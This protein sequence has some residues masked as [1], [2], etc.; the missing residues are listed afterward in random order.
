[1]VGQQGCLGQE[2]RQ[3]LGCLPVLTRRSCWRSGTH[4][5]CGSGAAPQLLRGQGAVRTKGAPVPVPGA[6]TALPG[7][8][9]CSLS[10]PGLCLLVCQLACEAWGSSGPCALEQPHGLHCLR[11]ICPAWVA[12]SALFVANRRTPHHLG[13]CLHR[14]VGAFKRCRPA[15][16][17]GK[18]P[19]II[20]SMYIS[21]RNP[22][23]G[24]QTWQLSPPCSQEGFSVRLFLPGFVVCVTMA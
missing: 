13:L 22:I 3:W 7:L 19:A 2:Q 4:I 9:P 6:G 16:S 20:S 21:E 1:M 15:V 24:A 18:H 8:C 10:C 11:G 12:N 5:C 14:Q 23:D 17:A